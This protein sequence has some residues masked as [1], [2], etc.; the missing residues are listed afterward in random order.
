MLVLDDGDVDA[1]MDMAAAIDAIEPAFVAQS[2]GRF[3]A[4]PR[5]YVT[6]PGRGDLV[7]TTGGLPDGPVGFR[8]Y[9]TLAGGAANA[10]I[11]AVWNAATGTLEGLVAG[12]RVGKMRT[13][14]IGGLAVRAMARE[15]A[16][17]AGI[18]GAGVQARTQI[19]AVAAV[20]QLDEARIYSR[21]D[22]GREVF[23]REMTARLGLPVRAVETAREAVEGV[24]I[25][26]CATT[27]REPVFDADWLAPGVHVNTVGPKAAG[28]HELP[29]QAAEAAAVVAT[30]SLAQVEA[31]S[32]PFFLDDTA[33]RADLLQLGDIVAGK[34]S[35]RK[36]DDDITLF[37]S[38]GLAGTEVLL[39]AEVI[40]R[41]G[42]S[43][44]G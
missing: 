21:T 39:A 31:M 42:A 43:A 24:D 13:G 5:N 12:E 19:E 44:R 23:A 15:D 10:Q 41:A 11:I 8:V 33:A 22:H 4:P 29:L 40:A 16:R 26:I 17:V 6:V 36:R 1:L 35:G 25:L 7:F 34:V 14:A 30:D 3:I 38:T 32:R 28:A 18:I 2:A 27:S 37:C 9:D 20:R